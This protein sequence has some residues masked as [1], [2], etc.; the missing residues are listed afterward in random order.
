MRPRGARQAGHGQTLHLQV[1]RRSS[2]AG[3]ATDGR[4]GDP[5]AASARRRVPGRGC[6]PSVNTR[7]TGRSRN[8]SILKEYTTRLRPPD[9]PVHS[10]SFL[11]A[12][13]IPAIAERTCRHGGHRLRGV[14][15]QRCHLRSVVV[16]GRF[17]GGRLVRRGHP[18]SADRQRQPPGR[19][20]DLRRAALQRLDRDL[21][22]AVPQYQDQLHGERLRRRDQGH[23]P[24]DDRFRWHGRRA[25]RHRHQRPAEP[26]RRSSTSRRPSARS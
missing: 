8:F 25:R 6:S 21:Q 11:H 4:A 22:R 5:A 2:G 13:S 15:Q 17:V 1:T 23:Q 24:A 14:L 10:R 12:G 16:V 20:L 7:H 26:A 3:P 18:R 9:A 19:R